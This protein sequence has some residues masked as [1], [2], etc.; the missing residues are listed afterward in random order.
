METKRSLYNT[1]G[2]VIN[3]DHTFSKDR[4][5]KFL[6]T[7]EWEEKKSKAVVIMTA[8]G[9]ATCIAFSLADSFDSY[10]WMF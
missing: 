1:R 5:H 10:A 3:A 6:L 8:P 7:L 9:E 2:G 4:N